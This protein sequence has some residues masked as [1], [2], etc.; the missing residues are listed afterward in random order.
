[1]QLYLLQGVPLKWKL[2][3]SMNYF[4]KSYVLVNFSEELMAYRGMY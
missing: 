2:K 3:Y 4:N 1:M